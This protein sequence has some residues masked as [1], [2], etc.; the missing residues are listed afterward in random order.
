M[1]AGISHQC[2]AVAAA[3][4]SPSGWAQSAKRPIV[5]ARSHR[6]HDAHFQSILKCRRRGE[7]ERPSSSSTSRR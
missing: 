2:R 6:D 3:A 1:N 7:S 5:Q 4:G